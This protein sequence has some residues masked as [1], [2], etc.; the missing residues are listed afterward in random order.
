MHDLT[1]L[2]RAA[3]E[4]FDQALRAVDPLSAVRSA[5]RLEKSTLI[6]GEVSLDMTAREIYAI[7]I[8]KAAAKMAAGLN[9]AL[10]SKISA[11]ILCTHE[12]GSDHS[13]LGRAWRSFRGGHPEPNEASLAAARACFELLAA[14]DQARALVIFLISGGGSAMIEAPARDDISLPDLRAANRLLVHSGA[15]IS[16][17]NSV[18]R[19]FSAV[20]G[21]K[22]AARV[23]NCD[24]IT[25]VVSDVPDGEEY[26]VASGPSIAPDHTSFAAG[27]V[28]DR[29]QL[30]GEL[31]SSIVRA[32]DRQHPLS[33]VATSRGEDFVL[34]SNKDARMAAAEAARHYGFITEIASDISDQPIA[35]G[36]RKLLA[37]LE[38][39]RANYPADNRAVCLISGGEFSCPAKGGGTGGRN[40]ETALRLALLDSHAGDGFVALCAG[41]DGIDGN[42]TAA[43]AIVDDTTLERAREMGLSA[44]EFLARSDSWSFFAALGD[45]I[46]TGPTGTNVRDLRI[47][48]G[49][50][51]AS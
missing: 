32:I 44:E 22:L 18:R 11:G 8:G 40:L 43:G 19:A 50:C 30:R 38:A 5:V 4:I 51:F 39:L 15:S 42:S 20:K 14:A 28:V 12:A 23:P 34:L 16:E 27:E 25:L 41:T 2:R 17:I 31:P 1:H 13:S 7:A 35:Q 10:G 3:R 47:L 37:S 24:R 45:A 49:G 9:Q 33:T 6:V 21:G 46:T 48:L 29:Y 36:C 26:N